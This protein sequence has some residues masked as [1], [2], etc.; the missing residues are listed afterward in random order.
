MDGECGMSSKPK[1]SHQTLA[2]ILWPALPP[3]LRPNTNMLQEEKY[4]KTGKTP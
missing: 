1:L 3:P 2:M 4:G